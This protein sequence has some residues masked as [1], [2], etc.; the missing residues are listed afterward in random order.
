MSSLLRTWGRPPIR[1]RPHA[2]VTGHAGLLAIGALRHLG[3]SGKGLEIVH[4]EI[5]Q[6]LAVDIHAG[7][8]EARHESAVAHPL[9][10]GRRVDAGD[11][12]GAELAF[13]LPPVTIG[14]PHGT[15]G[16][17]LG[18]LVQLAPAAT[19]TLGG[20][21][22]LLFSGVMGHAV[23]DPG[24]W[25]I[26]LRLKET[27]DAREIGRAD[28]ISLLQPVLPLAR[29]L[30]QNVTVV[31]VPALEFA[32]AGGLEALHRGSLRFLLRHRYP[33]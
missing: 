26:S 32:T 8:P 28:E 12:E 14:V 31:R 16:R 29:L 27:A 1:E 17:F 6:H 11:P 33:R 19:S 25:R 30:G 20:F 3:D 4:R 9:A 24:H 15:L 23:L 13:L 10:P 21:H 18:R 2:G 5:G 7:L 22:D